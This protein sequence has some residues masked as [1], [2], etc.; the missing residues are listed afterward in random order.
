ME[1][2]DM[3]RLLPVLAALLLAFLSVVSGALADAVPET[4]PEPT[5]TPKPTDTPTPAPTRTPEPPVFPK[6]S[7]DNI[8]ITEKS[9]GKFKPLPL[10]IDQGGAKLPKFKYTADITVYEDPTIRVEYHR[11]EGGKDWGV[12]Y[13]FADITIRDPSQI[14]TAFATRTKKFNPNA[15]IEAKGIAQRFNAVFAT[16]GDFFGGFSGNAFVLRQGTLYRDTVE[17]HL[18]VLLIDE[19]G[20]FHVL[21]ASKDLGSID[22]TT[23]DGKKVINAFQFGPA[24]VID[25]KPVKDKK[26]VDRGHSPDMAQPDLRNQRMCIM[27]ID[28]LHYMALCCAHYGLTLP[29]FRDL[30]IWLSGGK[31]QTVYTLDGGNSSQMIFLGRKKNNVHDDEEHRGITDIIYFASAWQAK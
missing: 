15:R 17:T 21:P 6:E 5:A 31:A 26:L 13:Y 12:V 27:Q 19:D 8:H 10:D 28:K 24:L 16:N 3:K 14:R 20:D 23:I 29:Q 2:L 25:G 4:T 7:R 18:D 9:G 11:V 1:F 30:A 22:K